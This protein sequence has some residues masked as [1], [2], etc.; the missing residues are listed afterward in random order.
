MTTTIDIATLK[1]S[2]DMEEP[3][4]RFTRRSLLA[5]AAV[6]PLFMGTMSAPEAASL[7]IAH[8]GAEGVRRRNNALQLRVQAAI[9]QHRVRVPAIDRTTDEQRFHAGIASFCK[10]LPHDGYGEVDRRAY[11]ALLRALRTGAETDFESIPMGG[12]AKLVSPQAALTFQLEGA[13][14]H[15]LRMPACPSITSI[16]HAADAVELYWLALTRDV[17]FSQYRVDVSIAAAVSEL[18][19]FDR[20]RNV[21]AENVFRGQTSG[22]R[23]GAYVSQFLWLPV[24]F[25]AMTL[26]QKYRTTAPG[27]DHLVTYEDLL[28]VQN[29]RPPS[30]VSAFDSVP[31]YIRSGRD[32]GEYVHRDFTYQAFLNAA[33]ILLG[34]GPAALDAGNP[35]RRYGKQ[36]GFASFG[37][38]DALALV[39]KVADYAIK[40]AWFQ[41]WLVHRKVRPEAYGGVVHNHM[42]DR[43]RYPVH[44]KLADC[45]ALGETYSRYGSYL[46]PM[47]YPEGCPLHPS[48]PAGHATIAGA[49]VTVLKAL[50]DEEFVVPKPVDASD[51]GLALNDRPEMALTVGGELNK[52]AANVALGRD[53]AG[54]HWRSDG[55]EGLRL[56]ESV[57]IRLLGDLKGTYAEY[58]D[59]F[60][61]TRFDGSD[62]TI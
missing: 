49:C 40:A 15:A 59:G 43:R 27:D 48:Y 12:A 31:R 53:T 61:L 46:L 19:R 58:S 30:T 47:A 56:G 36:A 18:Q 26:T 35:Y 55:I 13:D 41:K 23:V 2:S 4:S 54:V 7:G 10:G 3:Q 42:T 17:P 62:I 29:G 57:A 14:S 21:S 52:L 22:D 34:W 9:R 44:P 32:L 38:S 8:E 20:F 51:D 25:G 50:F 16:E 37:A 5:G 60:A 1:P 39:A 6:A 33:L 11:D 24:P 28:N 45:V